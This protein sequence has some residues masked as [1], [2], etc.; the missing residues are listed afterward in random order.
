M[1]SAEGAGDVSSLGPE[2][3]M[4]VEMLS[5]WTP[6]VLA[7]C[8]APLPVFAQSP[9]GQGIVTIGTTNDS[10][11]QDGYLDG[12]GDAAVAVQAAVG[13]FAAGSKGGEIV[14]LPGTYTFF[15][16]ATISVPGTTLRGSRGAVFRPDSTL[17]TMIEVSQLGVTIDGI[18][19]RDSFTTQ[20]PARVLI[21]ATGDGLCVRDCVV[22]ID[23]GDVYDANYRALDLGGSATPMRDV[24]VE[25]CSF[26]FARRDG[27]P[28]NSGMT[29]IRARSVRGIRLVG[30]HVT[31]L[32]PLVI[33]DS[34]GRVSRAF[35]LIDVEDVQVT[36]NIMYDLGSVLEPLEAVVSVSTSAGS[37]SLDVVVSANY[38]ENVSAHYVIN[39]ED[40]GGASVTANGIGRCMGGI[41]VAGGSPIPVADTVVNGNELHNVGH[42]GVGTYALR[43][44]STQG[45]SASGNRFGLNRLTQVLVDDGHDVNVIGNQFYFDSGSTLDPAILVIDSSRLHIANNSAHG[46]WGQV[47]SVTNSTDVLERFNQ[48]LE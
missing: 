37:A 8:F 40:V 33:L 19:F 41:R 17:G 26:R 16:T 22:E 30:N 23:Q 1:G 5:T 3:N 14:F 36:G 2:S 46:D 27:P 7:A 21:L 31:A 25:G 10:G 39:L 29:G 24:L 9:D 45:V 48:V 43:I 15:T 42:S 12:S 44:E 47:I 6:I 13:L 34:G 20:P 35:D 18:T 4:E 11:A 28:G 32:D 38:A